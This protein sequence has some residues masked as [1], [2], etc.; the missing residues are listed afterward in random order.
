[1][2]L[3]AKPEVDLSSFLDS[4][5]WKDDKDSLAVA[6]PLVSTSIMMCAYT[7]PLTNKWFWFLFKERKV[8]TLQLKDY[9]S[10]CLKSVQHFARNEFYPLYLQSSY[11]L[12][13][14]SAFFFTE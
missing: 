7:H 4:M 9:Q 1:M 13:F 11:F 12:L 8:K 3:A 6:W 14:S 2:A 10:A 5:R